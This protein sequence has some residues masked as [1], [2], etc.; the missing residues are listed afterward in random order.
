MAVYNKTGSGKGQLFW[1]PGYGS[2]RIWSKVKFSRYR[3]GVALRVCRGI[4]LL[5]L[6][7]G[8]RK[9]WVSAARPGRT[10]PPG[11][12]RYPFY[13]RLGG[14][15]RWSGRAE[16]HVPTGI[17]Y[18]T[19]QPLVSRYTDWA[20]GP[21]S[22][23]KYCLDLGKE[24]PTSHI[25]QNWIGHILGRNCHQNTLLKEM[26]KGWKEEEEDVSIL[27]KITDTWIERGSTSSHFLENSLWKRT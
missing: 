8:T 26:R 16:N 2:R 20:T 9:G 10:L 27:R 23:V 11:K 21:R 14:P 15:Q 3:P 13:R 12:T 18:R 25:Q 5:F 7:R 6:D 1:W 19:V 24:Y 22:N 17:R 4:A